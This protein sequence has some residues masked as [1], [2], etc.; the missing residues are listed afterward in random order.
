LTGE[1]FLYKYKLI[2]SIK[3]KMDKHPRHDVLAHREPDQDS[4]PPTRIARPDEIALDL[5][6]PKGI[7]HPAIP[8]RM[9]PASGTSGSS[10]EFPVSEV[11]TLSGI[12]ASTRGKI[13]G[14]FLTPEADLSPRGRRVSRPPGLKEPEPA[15]NLIETH[16]LSRIVEVFRLYLR[17]IESEKPAVLSE[18][19]LDRFIY[20][21]RHIIATCFKMY[22]ARFHTIIAYGIEAK[23]QDLMLDNANW[24]DRASVVQ[25]MKQIAEIFALP[26]EAFENPLR[27]NRKNK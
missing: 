22:K 5:T 8:D 24:Q 12:A 10:G 25:M 3:I 2:R 19:V 6:R 4:L 16:L 7:G 14:E 11:P 21:F 26:A 13:S 9:D 1:A 20:A 27:K 17:I 23:L 18:D 15:E